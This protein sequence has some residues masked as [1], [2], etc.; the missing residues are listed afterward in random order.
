VRARARIDGHAADR[1]AH[2][3]ARAGVSAMVVMI[4]V[5]MAGRRAWRRGGRLAPGNLLIGP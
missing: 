5:W 3:L 2:P 1:I 4:A